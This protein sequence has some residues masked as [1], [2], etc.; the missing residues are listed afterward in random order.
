MSIQMRPFTWEEDFEQVRI[1]LI[2]LFHKTQSLQNCPPT[3]FENRKFG[4]CGKIYQE[5]EDK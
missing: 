2:N 5:E 1:F 4:P 3:R